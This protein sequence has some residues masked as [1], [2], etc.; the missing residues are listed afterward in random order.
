MD[1]ANTLEM[2][3]QKSEVDVL[4]IGGGVNGIGTFRDLA[5]QGI[6]C[7]LVE[8]NDFCSGASAASSH[9]LHGGIR[10]LENGEFRLVRE[11]LNERNLLLKNAPHYAKP[12]PTAIPIFKWFSGILNAPLKFLGVTQKPKE[13]GA[14]V[15]KLGLIMY[16]LFTGAQQTM[17]YHRFYSKNASLKK[18]P[19]LN[20]NIICTANYYDAFI[21]YPERLCLDLIRDATK[22]NA[23]AHAL[24]YCQVISSRHGTVIFNDM[25]TGKTYDV[26]PKVIVN[27]AG[28]WIDLV[29]NAISEETRFI[30]GTK[31]SH[32]VVENQ[33][34]LDA[35]GGSEIFFEND[36]GRIVLILP[37]LNRVIIGT[38]DIRIDNPDDAVCTPEEETYLLS[39]VHKVFPS[40]T[41]KPEEI[42]FRFSGVRP[43]P[44]SDDKLTG[45]ISRD[46]SI[47]TTPPSSDFPIPVHSLIGG[48]WTTFRAFSEQA[49]DVVLH[50]LGRNRK[51]DTSG[52]PIGGGK[53]FPTTAGDRQKWL[54]NIQQKTELDLTTLAMLLDRYGT[55]AEEVAA[56]M[57][58]SKD[59]AL[60]SLPH[61][62]KREIEFLIRHEAVYHIE[63]LMLRRSLMAMLGHHSKEVIAEVGSIMAQVLGWDETQLQHEISHT[64]QILAAKHG[65]PM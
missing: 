15:I 49:A 45:T 25:L 60:A 58:A 7:L 6:S 61:Y 4:V 20:E 57:S 38:T 55:Y 56:Y 59:S 54:E 11:A 65:V 64:Q 19:N 37:Y 32:L 50:D 47:R 18:Y 3:A 41:V 8:K 24:N 31:G 9:M 42:V 12:L 27:A 52:I 39:L 53:G 23:D 36:D 46:H 14:I 5:L 10:Y 28:P 62:T 2:L 44:A 21:P 29:N 34:L 33:K 48:K 13:R 22:A 51:I 16:D 63:D 40:I 26:K 1:R 30:G 17:P 35:T 43:L